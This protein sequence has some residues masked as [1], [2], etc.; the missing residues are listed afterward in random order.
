MIEGRSIYIS[1]VKI[2]LEWHHKTKCIYLF[3]KFYSIFFKLIFSESLVKFL[4]SHQNMPF[5][6][7]PWHLIDY[8]LLSNLWTQN[9]D[10]KEAISTLK[11]KKKSHTV[12]Y[13]ANTELPERIFWMFRQKLT[14]HNGAV[15]RLIIVVQNTWDF[16]THFRSFSQSSIWVFCAKFTRTQTMQN[17]Q[18]IIF[19]ACWL[20]LF[21]LLIG[22]HNAQHRK[23]KTAIHLIIEILLN[24]NHISK[25]YHL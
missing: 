21:D 20:W 3:V 2:Y 4:S 25:F 8:F 10:H 5:C 19:I 1:V 24:Q 18:I 13:Q 9:G 15:R 22:I 11:E 16:L 7:I 14:N 6:E 17:T 23:N 12:P